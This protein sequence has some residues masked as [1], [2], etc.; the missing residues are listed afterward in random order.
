MNI[1]RVVGYDLSF[2][3]TN[4]KGETKPRRVRAYDVYWGFNEYHP[5]PQFLL[6]GLDL[7]KHEI[8]TFA[9]S[10]IRE[11]EQIDKNQN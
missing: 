1:K 9:M 5:E 3:Y 10:D 7:D 8:R 11:L 6:I 2:I 4:Y